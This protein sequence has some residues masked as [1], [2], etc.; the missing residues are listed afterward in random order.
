MPAQG[1]H[2]KKKGQVETEVVFL[3]PAPLG[4]STPAKPA[5]QGRPISRHTPEGPVQSD[6]L[7]GHERKTRQGNRQ[8]TNI[9]APET[10][11]ENRP[12]ETTIPDRPVEIAS[13][14]TNNP[15]GQDKP[16]SVA[17]DMVD[18][19]KPES[20]W[21]GKPFLF[22]HEK[23][24][25]QGNKQWVLAGTQLRPVE[26]VGQDRPAEPVQL[27]G[28]E[29]K[30]RQ[31]NK[32]WVVAGKNVSRRVKP[33]GLVG[34]EKKTKHGNKQWVV[35]GK[36]LGR[37]TPVK[38]VGLVGHE[39]KTRRGNKQW[40]VAGLTPRRRLPSRRN[41]LT[42][43]LVSFNG[44]RYTMDYS[45]RRLKRLSTSSSQLACLSP[46]ISGYLGGMASSSVKRMKARYVCVCSSRVRR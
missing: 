11:R 12:V 9:G 18:E 22:G 46:A 16:V 43:H 19:H 39:K 34:H 13:E 26:H 23:K 28:H 33:V 14:S 15:V 8:W 32:Q 35:A 17:T 40:V 42:K 45:G 25:R 24:T 37:R 4:K 7:Q 38:P 21:P 30:T 5:E 31:G 1:S 41:S 3:T 20:V 36:H 6:T 44:G 29:K 10:V 2:A 27:V